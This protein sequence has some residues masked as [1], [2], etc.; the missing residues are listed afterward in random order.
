MY[1]NDEF[2]RILLIKAIIIVW[3]NKYK[4]I[5]KYIL[6]ITFPVS[7]KSIYFEFLSISSQF[8]VSFFCALNSRIILNYI[9]DYLIIQLWFLIIIK[10][11]TKS[12]VTINK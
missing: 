2:I 7:N 3:K 12:M 6:F 5:D 4:K 8:E 11:I 10:K 9:Q 1:Y